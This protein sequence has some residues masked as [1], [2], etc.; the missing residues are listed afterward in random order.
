MVG[1]SQSSKWPKVRILSKNCLK[2][3]RICFFSRSGGKSR[4]QEC[5]HAHTPW[6]LR[7]SRTSPPRPRDIVSRIANWIWFGQSMRDTT[8]GN[9]TCEI[10][11]ES[12]I[13]MMRATSLVQVLCSPGIASSTSI[14]RAETL[15]LFLRRHSGSIERELEQIQETLS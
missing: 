12:I 7:E 1:W 15:V 4:D 11:G 2:T 3:C 9:Y 6:I 13:E 14:Q 5:H 8:A 10:E